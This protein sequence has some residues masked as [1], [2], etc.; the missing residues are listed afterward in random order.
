MTIKLGEYI[1]FAFQGLNLEFFLSFFKTLGNRP[2]C[3]KVIE[4]NKGTIK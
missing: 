1:A 2:D 3:Q 4:P